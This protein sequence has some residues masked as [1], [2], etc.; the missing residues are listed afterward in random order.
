[1]GYRLQREEAVDCKD[2][3]MMVTARALIGAHHDSR[4][5]QSIEDFGNGLGLSERCWRKV[6]VLMPSIFDLEV[7]GNAHHDALVECLDTV[8]LGSFHAVDDQVHYKGSADGW[9]STGLGDLAEEGS[10]FVG[11][12]GNRHS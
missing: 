3:A 8:V 11:K 4:R 6:V 2:A 5:W 1:M 10:Y 9:S 7:V 12:A